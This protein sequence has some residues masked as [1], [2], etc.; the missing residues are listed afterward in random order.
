MLLADA[1]THRAREDAFLDD[2]DVLKRVVLVEHYCAFD[3][4]EDLQ[5]ITNVFQLLAREHVELG[6]RDLAQ[7]VHLLG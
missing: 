1:D 7:E 4:F 2:V 3:A 6:R 5:G